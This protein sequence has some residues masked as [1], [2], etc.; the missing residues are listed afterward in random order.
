MIETNEVLLKEENSWLHYSRPHKVFSTGNISKVLDML[1]EVEALVN[2]NNW[3][4]AGFVSYEAAPAFDSAFQVLDSADFPLLWFGLYPKPQVVK[5]PVTV[6]EFGSLEW[7]PTVERESYN[8]SIE[9][10]K[11]YIAQG[12]TYQV[13]YTMRLQTKF[14]TSAW[15]FFLQLAQRQN[16]YAAY[17]NTGRYTICSASPELFFQLDGERIF[18]D[19]M[20]GTTKRGLTVDEDKKQSDWLR[21]SVKNRAENV[22]IVDMIRNDLGRIAEVGSVK[23]SELFKIEKYPTLFQ[24]TSTV[25]AKTKAS[26]TDIFS[27]LFPCASITG[28]PKV[29]TM[30]IIS[31]LETTPRKI[32]TGSIGYISPGRKAQFNVAIRTA[33][34]DHESKYA[35]YG[36]GGGIV[37]DSTNTDEYDEALL[38]SHV[39]TEHPQEFS[40]LETLLW[41]PQ[42]GY[43][44]LEKHIARIADSAA[45]FDFVFSESK[46]ASVL[47]K[48]ENK[49]KSAQRLRILLDRSGNFTCE[50]KDFTEENKILKV[51]LADEAIN[52]SN[53][54]Y[55]HK[56]TNRDMYPASNEFDD[57]LLYNENDEVTEFT[58]GNLVVRINGELVT[59][60]ISCGLLAGTFRAH[61][62]E[63]IQ[64]KERIIHKNELHICE[65]IFLVNSVRKWVK[66]EI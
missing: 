46:L 13:N 30:N 15:G 25:E 6:Q 62:L 66:V 45:Y 42:E 34:I 54:F 23:V 40:L 56:T 48:M 21:D 28:A 58:I 18:S 22:M 44:L 38:K 9:K 20:K 41:T 11:E 51:K 7:Q 59:P 35:E 57:I 50:T 19:P 3:H 43:F 53:S 47:K 16:K 61:L 33:L 64:I 55:F 60:P 65:E 2:K 49:F 29:S 26:V 31:E 63:S 14:Q 37:W 12:R 1:R 4:A 32:Y 36:V 8:T 27:A 10:I 52:S 5:V 24:M 39:L 17:L